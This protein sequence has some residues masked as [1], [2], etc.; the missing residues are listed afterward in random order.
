[1]AKADRITKTTFHGNAVTFNG[2]NGGDNAG[3]HG[4]TYNLTVVSRKKRTDGEEVK[5]MEA[6]KLFFQPGYINKAEIRGFHKD[7]FTSFGTSDD[8]NIQFTYPSGHGKG[9]KS[10]AMFLL[11]EK[12][13]PSGRSYGATG[14]EGLTATAPTR[15]SNTGQIG[16][17]LNQNNRSLNLLKNIKT[18][19]SRTQSDSSLNQL[20]NWYRTY[21]GETGNFENVRGNNKQINFS[22]FRNSQILGVSLVTTNETNSSHS[23]NNN[24]KL[25]VQGIY[26]EKFKYI[27]TLIAQTG[28][29]GPVIPPTTTTT[30]TTTPAP[31][32]T[33]PAPTTT[34]TTPKP[35]VVYPDNPTSEI[36]YD[37]SYEINSFFQGGFSISDT[38]LKH[39]IEFI[40]I[41]DLGYKIYEFNYI[42]KTQ[43]AERYQG[44]MAQD[45]LEKD[46]NHPA[47]TLNKDGYYM[48]DYSK[49][50]VEF[51]KIDNVLF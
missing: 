10:N 9:K 24:A 1:M 47:V 12:Q 15:I 14:V 46:T 18:S 23:G 50:D 32:T 26:G 35:E 39:D 11:S 51:K 6:G 7:G 44:V 3:G 38:R 5:S 30:T 41:S 13:D 17:G 37:Y 2:M 19:T 43:F 4:D 49:I 40:G 33:T 31:G 48:V 22:D 16:I 45:L 20:R 36:N 25:T 28:G 29:F 8:T 27:I 34:T 42:D 21:V